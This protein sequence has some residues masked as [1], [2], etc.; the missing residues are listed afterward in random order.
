MFIVGKTSL[1]TR[2][3]YDSFDNTYQ[4][5][6]GIDFLSKVRSSLYITTH[7]LLLTLQSSLD[8]V[9][10]RPDSAPPTLGYRRP[11]TLSLPN[12]FIYPRLFRRSGRLRHLISKILPEYAEMGGRRPWGTWQRCHHRTGGKQDGSW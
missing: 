3:M 1:I 5:T 7:I 6:I 8:D 12:P 2:F 9:P 11:R 10:R 4:A